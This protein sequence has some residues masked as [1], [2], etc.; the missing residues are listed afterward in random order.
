MTQK[1]IKVGNSA[2]VLLPAVFLKEA[3]MKIGDEIAVEYN[4]KIKMFFGK[5]KEL[6][7]KTT[8]TP[9]FKEWL[10]RTMEEYNAI[11][12]KLTRLD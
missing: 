11:L 6:A 1:I 9:E 12:K 2:A 8:L 7:D 4:G 5:P 3:N 10:D